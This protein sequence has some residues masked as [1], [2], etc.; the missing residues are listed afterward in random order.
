MLI[1]T[2]DEAPVGRP[3]G[4]HRDGSIQFTRYFDGS[5][6]TPGYYTFMIAAFESYF[7]PRHR[8][9]YDQIRYCLRGSLNYGRDRFIPE[10]WIGYFPEGT[11]YGPQDIQCTWENSPQVLTHQ[12][13]GASGQGFLSG[14]KLSSS[15]EALAARGRFEKGMFVS[16]GDDGKEHRQDGY[17]AAWAEAVGHQLA[18]PEGRF[19]EPVLMNPAAYRW[20]ATDQLGVSEK[21]LGVF[22][23]AD[24]KISFLRLDPGAVVSLAVRSADSTLFSMSGEM[25]I[26]G[27]TYPAHTGVKVEAGEEAHVGSA[28]GC[29]I[30]LV[31]LPNLTRIAG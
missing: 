4:H 2:S 12:F 11:F 23:E 5:V 30:Y 15:Y 3:Q 9:N 13:G 16:V 29:E 31:D 22:G 24:I 18:Y 20:R 7:T 17:E 25:Q 21:V 10:G 19:H 27:A 8:H 6:D 1:V 14:R 26:A 28:G